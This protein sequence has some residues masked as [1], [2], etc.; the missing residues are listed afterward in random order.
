M[1]LYTCFCLSDRSCRHDRSWSGYGRH[2]HWHCPKT[3]GEMPWMQSKSQARA[4]ISITASSF[5][6]VYGFMWSRDLLGYRESHEPC[7]FFTLL[8]YYLCLWSLLFSCSRMGPG[9][10]E[11]L[12]LKQALG[13]VRQASLDQSLLPFCSTASGVTAFT[14][15]TDLP[16]KWSSL[17]VMVPG[18]S[19]VVAMM[20]WIATSYIIDCCLF[21]CY[22]HFY[23]RVCMSK[24]SWDYLHRQNIL[25]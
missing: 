24:E 22:L 9:R 8:C 25:M 19:T 21:T 6:I 18:K 7:V 17:A 3:K 23:P 11:F 1:Q 12:P 16:P 15:H 4:G 14:M 13:P 10:Q 2:H 5:S 20:T